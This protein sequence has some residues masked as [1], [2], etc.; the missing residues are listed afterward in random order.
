M[1]RARI[2]L[3]LAWSVT[4]FIIICSTAG[5]AANFMCARQLDY[6]PTFLCIVN[7]VVR[8]KVT[9]FYWWR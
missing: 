7:A 9:T 3:M 2:Q 4:K 1:V 8:E 6:N 5:Y